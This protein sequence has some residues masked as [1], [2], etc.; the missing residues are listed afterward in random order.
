MRTL[1]ITLFIIVESVNSILSQPNLAIKELKRKFPSAVK[2]KWTK[3]D[4][5]WVASFNL[6][7]RKASAEFTPDGHWIHSQMEITL[8]EIGVK[9]VRSAITKDFTNC[10]IISII[11]HNSLFSGTWYDVKAKCGGK[12]RNSSYDYRGWPWP[13]RI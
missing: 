13:P 6:K 7:D 11:I 8:S 9:E 10:E 5:Y 3:D 2:I 1:L 12:E 4:D